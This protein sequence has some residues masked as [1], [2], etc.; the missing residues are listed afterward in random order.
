MAIRENEFKIFIHKN[1]NNIHLRLTG[2][3]DNSSAQSLCHV[4]EQN[5]DGYSAVFIHTANL[6]EV[7]PCASDALRSSAAITKYNDGQLIF[8]G[9]KARLVAPPGSTVV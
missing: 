5:T 4:L 6:D 2:N 9:E 8:T 1:E 3:F 7:L